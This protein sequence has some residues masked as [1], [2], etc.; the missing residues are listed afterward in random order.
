MR[1]RNDEPSEGCVASVFKILL[2]PSEWRVEGET[3]SS[4]AGFDSDQVQ[5]FPQTLIIS[6]CATTTFTWW[7]SRGMSR[8]EKIRAAPS[9][10]RK[11]QTG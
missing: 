9:C 11:V 5:A 2:E 8:R 1:L 3:H 4:S 7:T 10:D 6:P